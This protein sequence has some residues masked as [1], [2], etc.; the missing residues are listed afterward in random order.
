MR[1]FYS[2]NTNK[3]SLFFEDANQVIGTWH[4]ALG[5]G[6]D[7]KVADDAELLYLLDF[8]LILLT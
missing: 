8:A 3:K 2:A 7:I 4:H 6:L 1:D 5:S